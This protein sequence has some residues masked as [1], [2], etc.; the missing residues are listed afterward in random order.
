MN[1]DPK[2][3]LKR[4]GLAPSKK[5]GQNFLVNPHT[6]EKI[7]C[8][9]H[10]SE[11]DHVLEI[12]VGFGAL[13]SFVAQKAGKVTGIEIDK[14]IIRFHE[15]E[16]DLPANV[17]LIHGDILK[18]DFSNLSARTGGRLKII[19]N[20]PY[21]ISNPFLF[22]LIEE[23]T[24]VDSVTLMLQKEVADRL[25]ASPATK[26]YGIPTVL[27]GAVAQIEKVLTLKPDEFFP[28]PKIDS[29]VI[30][31]TFSSGGN[32]N[33]NHFQKIVRAAFA[34][35]RKTVLNNLSTPALFP[36]EVNSSPA[37]RRQKA[38]KMIERT[39]IS[40]KIR[41]EVL[42]INQFRLLADSYVKTLS[43]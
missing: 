18:L 5:F 12:G 42:T 21:S 36:K 10:F 34:H 20:L 19:A 30:Q 38:L 26:S 13:T 7:A 9:G 1:Q 43:D 25:T 14:G 11:E 8:L 31:I 39:G 2:N 24:C 33:S 4:Y 15:S 27:L 35:R 37:E 6:A 17:T 40:P 41:A 32:D 23:H 29:Q 28:R 22:K 3:Y 16:K